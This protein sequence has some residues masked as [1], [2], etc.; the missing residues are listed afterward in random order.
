MYRYLAIVNPVAGAGRCGKLAP[1]AISQ[2]RDSGLVVDVV[3]TKA[4]AE[5]THIARQAY[6]EGRRHFIAVGGD[7]TAFEIVDGLF[8]QAAAREPVRLGF[9]PMGTGNSFLRDF[10]DRGTEYAMESLIHGVGRTC[11]VVRLTHEHG[12]IHYINVMTIGFGAE[13]GATTNR[14][15]K[16]FGSAGYGLSVLIN[17]VKLK[18]REYP[19]RLDGGAVWRQPTVL[20]S[21]CNSRYTGGKMMMA[22]SADTSDGMIDLIS[23]GKMGRVELLRNFPKIFAGTH[24]HHPL[25]K[26]A[27]AKCIDFD[28][29]EEIDMVVDGEVLH[30]VPRQLTVLAGAL[31]VGV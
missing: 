24:I 26:S 1:N 6:T 25:I 31:E 29:S 15:F 8:P 19:F 14:Y 2:L 22:P 23:V 27:R 21:F 7:G 3:E 13:V 12:T 30:H 4:P 10:S 16:P 18:S 20:T 11:D 5:A 17:I 9:L 28:I